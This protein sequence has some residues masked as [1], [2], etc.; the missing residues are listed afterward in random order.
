MDE[1]VFNLIYILELF[2]DNDMSL[3]QANQ[4]FQYLSAD[5]FNKA[6]DPYKMA[7]GGRI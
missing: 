4:H 5:E 7:K 3:L 2:N 1:T 6:L